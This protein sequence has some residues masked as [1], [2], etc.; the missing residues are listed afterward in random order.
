MFSVVCAL[1]INLQVL[2]AFALISAHIMRPQLSRW[3]H[4]MLREVI[5]IIDKSLRCFGLIMEELP[6]GNWRK[7]G[8]LELTE[9]WFWP[10]VI[11]L[12][13]TQNLQVGLFLFLFHWKLNSKSFPT[14]GGTPRGTSW[15]ES[16][17]DFKMTLW[18]VHS[19][20]GSGEFRPIGRE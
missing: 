11:V 19:P 7:E 3:S 5:I 10:L 4:E 8:K 18:S 16:Y 1:E 9:C 6:Q 17:S 2:D 14:I 20:D 12:I 13:I 15:A